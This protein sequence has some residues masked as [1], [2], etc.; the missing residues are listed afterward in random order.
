MKYFVVDGCE[1]MLLLAKIKEILWNMLRD[2]CYAKV[3]NWKKLE[4]LSYCN[5]WK[6]LLGS[7][8]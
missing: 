2:V 3:T 4:I 6:Y 7:G 1:I 8:N 5:L